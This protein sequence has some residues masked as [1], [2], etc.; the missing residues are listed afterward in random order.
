M[1]DIKFRAYSD[2]FG[3]I[4]SKD[5][6]IIAGEPFTRRL[7]R[8]IELQLMQYTGLLDKSGKEIYEGDILTPC[9]YKNWDEFNLTVIFHKGCFMFDI[10]KPYVVKKT[11]LHECLARGK[12]AANGYEIIGNIH[13]N[14]ELLR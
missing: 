13:E 14:P 9:V 10:Q 12:N 4:E 1:R 6:S 7:D 11:E 8:H 5:I 2:K 3:M